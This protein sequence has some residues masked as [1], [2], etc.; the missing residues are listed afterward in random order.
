[1]GRILATGDTPAKRRN[2]HL[3]SCAE[4][5]RRLAVHPS[6]DDEARD[7]TAFLVLN[8]RGIWKTIDDS[9]DVWAERDYYKKSEA[10]RETWR[11]TRHAAD[12]LERLLRMGAYETLPTHLADLATRLSD[13][14]VTTLTRDADWWCGAYRALMKGTPDT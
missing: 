12:A 9:A 13:V 8:L 1:M 6:F 14:R 2:A 7:L 3:R 11:W 4:A 5:V 10:L